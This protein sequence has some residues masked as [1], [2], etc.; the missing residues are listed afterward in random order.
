MDLPET[1][2]AKTP[3][4]V[5][6]AYQV[7]GEGPFDFVAVPS[8]WLGA[9]DLAWDFPLI[10]AANRFF[11]ARG[12]LLLFD[13]RGS[14]SSDPVPGDTPARSSPASRTSTR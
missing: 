3:D 1:Q 6:I 13:R 7:L 9:V 12:K 5:H 14:G 8:M 10:S 11:S 4:G 2:Y